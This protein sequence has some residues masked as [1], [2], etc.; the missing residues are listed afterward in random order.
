LAELQKGI[1]QEGRPDRDAGLKV[2]KTF[3]VTP[4]VG[5]RITNRIHKM[6]DIVVLIDANQA[7]SVRGPYRKRDEA[8]ISN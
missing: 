1:S 8:Q 4:A 5:A 7:P 6:D 3:G 2:H